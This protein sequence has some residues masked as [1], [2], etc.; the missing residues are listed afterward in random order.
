VQEKRFSQYTVREREMV[1]N[2]LYVFLPMLLLL[3][4]SCLLLRDAQVTNG[5]G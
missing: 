5:P 2:E 3:N 1:L 4:I